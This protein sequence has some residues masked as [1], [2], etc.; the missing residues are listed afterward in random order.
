MTTA[1]LEAV[2][3][4]KAK[5][6]VKPLLPDHLIGNPFFWPS[7]KGVALTE[8]ATVAKTLVLQLIEQSASRE[9][10][11]EPRS[12]MST[13][14]IFDA[15]IA[16]YAP[17]AVP[18]LVEHAASL[19]IEVKHRGRTSE[20][21]SRDLV[22]LVSAEDARK[23]LLG[24]KP[25]YVNADTGIVWCLSGGSEISRHEVVNLALRRGVETLHPEWRPA[26]SALGLMMLG[27]IMDE[28]R[29]APVSKDDHIPWRTALERMRAV[30][31]PVPL[32]DIPDLTANCGSENYAMATAELDMRC[33]RS[34]IRH[35]A[36]GRRGA[37][38]EPVVIG[39]DLYRMLGIRIEGMDIELYHM[40]MQDAFEKCM[41][42]EEGV[43]S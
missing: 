42:Q 34:C 7:G 4:V 13:I 43:T 23:I 18:A 28:E 15:E 8:I 26:M 33:W 19:G 10:A 3:P 17:K 22:K 31:A 14:S 21:S 35:P 16:R 6:P 39:F 11:V 25:E 37:K 2:R 30:Q 29:K 38:Q 24:G 9:I 40:I 12:N 5:P 36:L 32:A 1:T 20:I 27:R 41:G